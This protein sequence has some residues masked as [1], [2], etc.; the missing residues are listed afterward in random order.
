MGASGAP[1]HHHMVALR[2]L[3]FNRCARMRK[4]RSEADGE[5]VERLRAR[6]VMTHFKVVPDDVACYEPLKRGR[7]ALA[8]ILEHARR[9]RVVRSVAA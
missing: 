7:G 6:K 2:K 3:G 4:G 1:P 9:N 5:L 8:G